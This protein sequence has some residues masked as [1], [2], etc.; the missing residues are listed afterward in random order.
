[1]RYYE[2]IETKPRQAT[3]PRAGVVKPKAPLTPAEL[4]RERERERG[5]QDRMRDAQAACARK[6]TDLRSKL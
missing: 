3:E 4:A 1:M 5:L 2:L 6:L